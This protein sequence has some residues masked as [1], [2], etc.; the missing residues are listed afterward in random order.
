MA[1]AEPAGPHVIRDRGQ[2]FGTVTLALPGQQD[3]TLLDLGTDDVRIQNQCTPGWT[4]GVKAV[5]LQ[6]GT[7]PD[8]PLRTFVI[9]VPITIALG[10]RSTSWA[11]EDA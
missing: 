5:H 4:A 9:A 7:V 6:L 8:E 2:Q 10:H 1:N 11:T 3:P